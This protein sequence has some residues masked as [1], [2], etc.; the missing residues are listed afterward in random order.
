MGATAGVTVIGPWLAARLTMLGAFAVPVSIT[1][2]AQA[3]VAVPSLLVFGRLPLVSVPANLLA[4]PVA[5]AVMLYGLPV[6]LLAGAVPGLG[7]VLMLPAR[8]GTRWVDTVAAVAA[9]LEPDGQAV[10]L[11]WLAIIAIVFVAALAHR[12]DKNR[13]S[14]DDPPPHR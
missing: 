6:G 11:G 3:G 14:H 2:G 4:V 13:A 12:R 9:R 8:F 1:L 10:V 5:G 7:A